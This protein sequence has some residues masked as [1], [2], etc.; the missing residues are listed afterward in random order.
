MHLLE[1]ESLLNDALGLICMRVAVAAALTGTLS[2]VDAFATFLWVAIG[3]I[4]LGV[5]VTWIGS[6]KAGAKV[7]NSTT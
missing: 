7:A 1:G 3:A 2:L 6:H 5:G 4:A